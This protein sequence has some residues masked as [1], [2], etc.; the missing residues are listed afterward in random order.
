MLC[1]QF[2]ATRRKGIAEYLDTQGGRQGSM[3][4]LAV[5]A[6]LGVPDEHA[7]N[8]MQALARVAELLAAAGIEITFEDEAEI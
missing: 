2:A 6:E 3:K 8:R 4:L 5:V 7:Q 1:S